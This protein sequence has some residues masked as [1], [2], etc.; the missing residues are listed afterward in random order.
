M[1]LEI[2]I[3]DEGRKEGLAPCPIV[4]VNGEY[5]SEPETQS[6]FLH[7]IKAGG[8]SNSFSSQSPLWL[9]SFDGFAP[10]VFSH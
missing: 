5:R 3:E 6:H 1:H 8:F 9:P 4:S 10:E 7:L 2:S